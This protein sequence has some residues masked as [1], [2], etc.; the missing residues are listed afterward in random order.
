MTDITIL[1]ALTW[2]TVVFAVLLIAAE[3]AT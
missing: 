2:T 1:L 3:G